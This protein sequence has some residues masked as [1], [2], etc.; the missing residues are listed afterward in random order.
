MSN[1]KRKPIFNL[2][3][4]ATQEQSL[5]TNSNAI[6]K[7]FSIKEVYEMFFEDMKKRG[8][9]EP[10]IKSQYY[11]MV[12]F[13]KYL[14]LDTPIECITED[15]IQG[16]INNMAERGNSKR[17]Q[18]TN[19]KA[20]R[21]FFYWAMKEGFLDEFK[22]HVPRAETVQLEAYTLEE[23]QKLLVEPNLRET[24]FSQYV[25][26]VAI[27]FF[28]YTGCRTGT[29]INV[30]I[31]DVDFNAKVI[32]FRHTKNGKEHLV[33]LPSPLSIVLKKYLKVRV[34]GAE[35][36]DIGELP[37]FCNAYGEKLN[38]GKIYKYVMEYNHKRGVERTSLHAF[39]RF[40][41][42]SLVMQGVPIPK[43]QYLVQH[44]RADLVTH[45]CKLYSKDLIE[46][47]ELFSNSIQM[48]DNKKRT[49]II[50]K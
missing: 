4:I 18:H 9:S 16:Y 36:E 50:L 21:T 3:V 34:Q 20:I 47:V 5:K 28:V 7:N 15:D 10:T 33:P 31:E 48:L 22:I 14:S 30:L 19:C 35:G 43:I 23:V 1:N 24:R 11:I 8:L 27:N 49:R 13:G 2:D 41:V 6:H 12:S 25:A 45:Y 29:L 38:G 46:D 26:Y 17:T 40:Y 42:K 44:S 39:R 37:L 32:K